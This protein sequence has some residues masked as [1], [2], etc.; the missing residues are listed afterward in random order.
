M[1]FD[2]FLIIVPDTNFIATERDKKSSSDDPQ[3][4]MPA[5]PDPTFSNQPGQ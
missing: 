5:S 1:S 3:Q 4:M 2:H